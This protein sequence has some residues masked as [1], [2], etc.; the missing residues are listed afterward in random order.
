MASRGA[1]RWFSLGHGL[2]SS[3]PSAILLLF[4]C[5]PGPGDASET[6]QGGDPGATSSETSAS[7]VDADPTTPTVPTTSTS[8][9][10]SS[11]SSDD[12]V[13]PTTQDPTL[14]EPA[15]GDG[16]VDPGETCD[17]GNVADGDCCSADCAAGP[18]EPGQEC[19]TLTI[20]G[21]KN[22]ADQGIAVALDSAANVYVLATV[23]DG[24]AQADI[25]IRKYDP[26]PFSQWT[27]QYDGGVSGA[28]SST[29]MV[30]D[31][32]G[33]MIALGRQTL[34][35]GEPSVPWISKCTPNGQV[36]WALTDPGLSAG[37]DVAL[38]GAGGDFV[39]A[40]VIKQADNDAVVRKYADGG[41]ELWTRSFSGVDQG[42]DSASGIA[43]DD[44]GNI[45]AVGREF[46]DAEKFNIWIQQ[47][48]PDG[49]PGWGASFD[50]GMLGNDWAN[51]V[52]I[53]ETGAAV[54]VGRVEVGLGFSDAWIRKYDAEGAE[55]WT[56]TY[57][58][59][60]GESDEGVAVA[61]AP[62]GDIVVV[63]KTAIA[64]QGLDIFVR[65]LD[66]DGEPLWTRTHGADDDDDVGDVAVGADGSV[67]VSGTEVVVPTLNSDVWVRKYSP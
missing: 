60:L 48:D 38:A 55:L 25:L 1:P 50:G 5:A 20:E 52:A 63:G 24:L 36:V 46:T 14:V 28:D 67:V 43:V 31:A 10:D 9:T 18:S 15:C 7:S 11:S 3:S 39:V 42:A 64:E 56:T 44:A 29:A 23:V 33:F 34:A 47:Y 45:L 37:L 32:D 17:D 54:V 12:T 59:E 61:F 2:V 57:A 58:G 53:D 66:A 26:G 35:M 8:A 6:T 22:G 19:W 30:G 16:V 41:G 40:G 49:A 4:A 65:K 21:T 27:Q 51:G 62:G 13:M